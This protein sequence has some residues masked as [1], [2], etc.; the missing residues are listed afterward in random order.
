[1]ASCLGRALKILSRLSAIQLFANGLRMVFL[2]RKN[3]SKR[4]RKRTPEEIRELVIRL[5]KENNWGYTRILG[6]LKKLRIKSISRS[7]VKRI[8]REN[9]LEYSS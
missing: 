2:S 8:L 5:A 7:T 3:M 1:M 9:G 4:G 6:E